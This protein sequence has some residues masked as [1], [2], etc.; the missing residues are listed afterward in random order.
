MDINWLILDVSWLI[1]I[2]DNPQDRCVFKVYC[3]MNIDN[4]H[5][6]Y[7]IELYHTSVINYI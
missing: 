4:Y 7:N 2:S 1:S 3:G 5:T 6:V